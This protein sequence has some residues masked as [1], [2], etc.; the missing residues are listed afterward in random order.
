MAG[1]LLSTLPPLRPTHSRLY[2]C[3]HGETESNA[4]KL[5]QGSGVNAPLNSKGRQQA[6]DLA[7]Q[8]G[9]VPLDVVAS[10]TLSRAQ[11]TATIVADSHSRAAHLER[12]SVAELAEMFYGALEGRPLAECRTELSALTEAWEAGKT[13]VAVGGDGESPDALLKRAQGALWD[14]GLLGSR[15]PGRHVAVVAHSSL[16]KA[17]LAVATGKGLGN[18]MGAVAQ[19]NCCINVL[20]YDVSAGEVQVVALNL[21]GHAQEG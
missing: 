21:V 12:R 5:L 15:D 17:V 1:L 3:R 8:L 19:D 9:A 2:L 11:A 4:Q 13:D 20:D 7:H 14:G 10:S 16:N 18:M 6:A